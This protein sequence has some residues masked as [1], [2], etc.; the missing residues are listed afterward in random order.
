MAIKVIKEG[1]KPE[2]KQMQG[3]CVHCGC[4][5]ECKQGDTKA[6]HDQREGSSY[7]IACPTCHQSMNVRPA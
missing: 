1:K 2:G 4:V 7:S 5:V 6:F 3:T